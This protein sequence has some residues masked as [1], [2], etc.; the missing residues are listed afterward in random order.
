MRPLT[1]LAFA[2]AAAVASAEE[3]VDTGLVIANGD[4]LSCATLTESCSL[5]AVKTACPETC[6]TCSTPESA[7]SSAPP[8]PLSNKD[9]I[10]QIAHQAHV[11]K[12]G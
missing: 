10:A 5:Q 12:E 2:A 3:C 4:V 1:A 7:S 9:R 6:G 8:P 11:L